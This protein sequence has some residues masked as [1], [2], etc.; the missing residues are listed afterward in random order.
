LQDA[1]N[2]PGVSDPKFTFSLVFFGV[3]WVDS[4]NKLQSFVDWI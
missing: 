4:G 3:H 1:Q 2:F